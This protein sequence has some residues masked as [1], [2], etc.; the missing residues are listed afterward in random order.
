MRLVFL[1][2]LFLILACSESKETRLQQL[3]LKGNI[4]IKEHNNEQ[5]LYYYEQALKLEPCFVDALN[6]KGTVYFNQG[7]WDKAV[8]EYDQAITCNRII[9]MP[10]LIVRMHIMN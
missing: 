4:A 6:N 2:P 3:L 8:H 1:L 7:K 9:S 10:T 5:A